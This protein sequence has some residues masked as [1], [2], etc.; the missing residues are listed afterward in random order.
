MTTLSERARA[1]SVKTHLERHPLVKRKGGGKRRAISKE[2]LACPECGC[3]VDMEPEDD[4]GH[5]RNLAHHRKF[6]K[7][8]SLVMRNWPSDHPEFD[9]MGSLDAMRGWLLIQAGHC[10][11]LDVKLSVE[12]ATDA[13]NLTMFMARIMQ[14]ATKLGRHAIIVERVGFFCGLIARSIAWDA[15]GEREFM[16]IHERVR[17]VYERE[18]F[19]IEALLKQARIETKE[20]V[21]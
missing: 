14:A 4:S 9:P 2:P 17:D 21:R 8:A 10:D 11:T 7:E 12:M 1:A 20:N 13:A 3:L 5:P 19:D 6:F 18:G 16:A 15:C